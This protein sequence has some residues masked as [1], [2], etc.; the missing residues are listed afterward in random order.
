MTD[1][2]QPETIGFT[3]MKTASDP[4]RTQDMSDPD[5]AYDFL[6]SAIA[7]QDAV[8][9]VDLKKLRRKVD[10]YIVPVMFLCYT[11]QFIDKVSLNVC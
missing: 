1:I 2:K 5:Q 11:V 4:S 7:S 10:W 6:K 9:Q 3:A 8:A